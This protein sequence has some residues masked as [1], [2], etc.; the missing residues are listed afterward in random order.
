MVCLVVLL[1]SA[2]AASAATYSFTRSTTTLETIPAHRT[3]TV[4]TGVSP[5]ALALLGKDGH[6]RLAGTFSTQRRADQRPVS[7]AVTLALK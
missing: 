2:G 3:V 5:A 4:S 1:V 6:R 7:S